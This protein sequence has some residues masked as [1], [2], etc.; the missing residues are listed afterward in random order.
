M[1]IVSSSSIVGDGR[2]REL[3]M[4]AVVCREERWVGGW[5]GGR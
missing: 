2:N 1:A 4:G 5:V 3:G